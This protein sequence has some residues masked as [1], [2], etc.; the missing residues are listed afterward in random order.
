[1]GT[2]SYQRF[3]IAR[4]NKSTN[5]NWW[6]RHQPLRFAAE[7]VSEGKSSKLC[8]VWHFGYYMRKAQAFMVSDLTSGKAQAFTVSYLKLFQGMLYFNDQQRHT[9]CRAYIPPR[10][11]RMIRRRNMGGRCAHLS[12]LQR[13]AALHSHQPQPL[14]TS[15]HHTRSF[16]IYNLQPADDLSH[17]RTKRR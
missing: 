17:S 3:K 7:S 8:A 1:M 6:S 4:V 13:Q 15:Y 2:N 10:Q 5:G 16:C 11:W 9:G 14:S 12:S